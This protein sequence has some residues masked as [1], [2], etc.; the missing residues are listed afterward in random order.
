MPDLYNESSNNKAT[1]ADFYIISESDYKKI[2]E[3]RNL[4]DKINLE[5]ENEAVVF[6]QI[7]NFTSEHDY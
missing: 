4:N 2:A 5:N 7:I 1:E 3:A 6:N